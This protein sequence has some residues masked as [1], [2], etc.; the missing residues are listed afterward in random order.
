MGAFLRRVDALPDGV[1]KDVLRLLLFLGGQR[2][3]QLLRVTPA[4]IDLR[5]G[6]VTL[7]DGK[8]A[9]REPR[10]HVL[11]LVTQAAEIL[12]RRLQWAHA[13]APLFSTDSRTTM[14]HETMSVL[15][16]EISTELLRAKQVREDFELRD[17]RRT[18]ET[19]LAALKVPSDIRAQLLSHGLGGV[20][21]RHYDRHDYAL[22]KRQ[23]LERW[24]RHLTK[25]KATEASTA[26]VL[27][28]SEKQRR[29]NVGI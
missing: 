1:Q 15:V 21:N 7:Y 6:T 11:P 10:R 14:R 19:M 18:T 12:E 4:D 29:M 17:L 27:Y 26:P 3:M 28:P 24:A 16:G 20:Q 5:A 25:L 22:E 23:A 8:G 2:P 9:R 13:G